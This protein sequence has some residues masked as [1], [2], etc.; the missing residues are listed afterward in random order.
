LGADAVGMSTAPETILARHVG[1]RVAA[2]SVMTNYAAGLVPGAIGHDQTL[3]VANAA[4]GQLG[5]LLRGFLE[6]YG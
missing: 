6:D 1:L 5:R 4:A 3:N 2:I